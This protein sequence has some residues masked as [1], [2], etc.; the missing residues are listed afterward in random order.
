MK[1]WA[2]YMESSGN[3]KAAKYYYELAKDYLSLVRLLC[4]NNL[5]DEV[6]FSSIINCAYQLSKKN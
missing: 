2:Q 1:W 3:I 6:T 5:I 4:S